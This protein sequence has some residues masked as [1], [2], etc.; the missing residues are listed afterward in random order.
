MRENKINIIESFKV[1]SGNEIKNIKSIKEK[2]KVASEKFDIENNYE[3]YKNILIIDDMA[4]TGASMCAIANKVKNK[5]IKIDGFSI[6]GSS[7]NEIVSD[8]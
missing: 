1:K 6:V 7:S 5:D 4:N 3:N 8:I 2:F